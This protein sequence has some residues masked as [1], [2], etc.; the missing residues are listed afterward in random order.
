LAAIGKKAAA[1]AFVERLPLGDGGGSAA[2]AA[3]VKE[4]AAAAFLKSLPL[5]CGGG[6]GVAAA[7]FAKRHIDINNLI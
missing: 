7:A 6:G 4:A 2:A 3:F 1:A 5:G